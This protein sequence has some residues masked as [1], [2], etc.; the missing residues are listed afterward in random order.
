[1]YD[2]VII[3]GGIG[4]LMTAYRLA[5]TNT[6]LKIAIIEQGKELNKRV[7]PMTIDHGACRH[8]STCAI[9]HGI[10]GAGAF[11]DGKFNMGTAYGGTLGEELGEETTMKYID[12]LDEILQQYA[13]DYPDIYVSDFYEVY[14]SSR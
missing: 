9:T 10:S 6:N 1:M 13:T 4:G 7:C 8:C 11:S 5:T 2:V 12:L 3:G 14:R